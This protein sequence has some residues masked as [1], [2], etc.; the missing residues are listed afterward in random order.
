MKFGDLIRYENQSWL[1][2][3]YDDRFTKQATLQDAQGKRVEIPIDL[4]ATGGCEVVAHPATEWPFIIV[5]DNPKG[6]FMVQLIRTVNRQRVPLTLYADWV[7]SD[8]ARPG[9]SIFLNPSLG[10]QPAETLVVEWASSRPTAVQV[11][12]HFGTVGQ[13]V[14]R[15]ARKA[16]AEVTAFDQLLADRF[17]EDT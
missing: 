9:G 5:R 6:K 12:V 10:I 13:R 17:D 16:P 15:A 7:P 1:V 3:R 11:P 14:E 4:D 2:R 8:P